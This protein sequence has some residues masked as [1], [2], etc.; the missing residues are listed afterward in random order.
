MMSG[1]GVFG[2]SL[3]HE[4]GALMDEING[5]KER[6]PKELTQLLAY[7]DTPRRQLSMNQKAGSHQTPNL[8]IP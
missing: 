8:L 4:R 2:K 1:D 5:L 3:G 6:H 7:E